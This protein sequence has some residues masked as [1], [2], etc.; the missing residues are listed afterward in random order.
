M[1]N[2]TSNLHLEILDEK[3]N[4]LLQQLISSIQGFILGGGTALSLQ[5]AHRKS[6]DFDFLSQKEIPKT[7][8][9]KLSRIIKI[10]TIANDSSDELTFFDNNQI[11]VT[12][13]YYPFKPYFEIAKNTHKLPLFSVKEIAIQ[14][15]YTIG[16]RGEYRDYFDLYTILKN[17]YISLSEI[18]IAAEKMYQGLFN[19]KLFLQQLV[20]FDDLLSFEITPVENETLP[21]KDIV[22]QYFEHIVSKYV[23]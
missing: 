16:R 21:S 22:K 14:K 15:A 9:E 6:F 13:L 23:T 8:A 1:N 10:H 4:D 2:S 5:I 3:R 18:V 12:F 11:K 17:K 19:S 20:Y 7:L